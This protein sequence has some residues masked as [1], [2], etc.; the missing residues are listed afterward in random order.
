MTGKS[1]EPWKVREEE[2]GSALGNLEVD[3]ESVLQEKEERKQRR[4][5]SAHRL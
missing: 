2:I 4:R 1:E 5:I 3:G